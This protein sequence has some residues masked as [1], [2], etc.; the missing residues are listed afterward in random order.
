M[1]RAPAIYAQIGEQDKAIADLN[2]A[3]K[4]VPNAAGPYYNRGYSYFAKGQYDRAIADYSEAIKLNPRMAVGLQQPLPDARHRRQGPG[5]GAARLRRGAEAAAGHLDA[6]DTRG[7]IY[8]KLG[9]FPVSINE[10]NASLQAR[11]EPCPG[12]VRPR[13]GEDQERRQAGRERRHGRRREARPKG[14]RGLLA[15]RH[16]VTGRRRRSVGRSCLRALWRIRRWLPP[17]SQMIY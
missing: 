12:A 2:E 15:L 11:S 4:L 10:Y 14:R 13:P 6:R 9:D 5:R 7:F 8:L 17:A 1:S 3:I 16:E